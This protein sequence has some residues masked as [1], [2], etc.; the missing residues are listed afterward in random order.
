MFLDSAKRLGS[1]KEQKQNKIVLENNLNKKSSTDNN[2]IKLK[3]NSVEI[4]KRKIIFKKCDYNIILVWFTTKSLWIYY[5]VVLKVI[6]TETVLVLSGVTHQ[7]F[8]FFSWS[9]WKN[10]EGKSLVWRF[11]FNRGYFFH[12]HVS[13][14]LKTFRGSNKQRP[15]W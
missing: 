8:Y 12:Q 11:I 3:N 9:S 15:S 14:T 5:S 4:L 6:E 2:T 13:R 1:K 10:R 7:Y